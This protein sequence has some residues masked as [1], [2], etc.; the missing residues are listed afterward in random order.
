M[1]AAPDNWTSVLT[2]ALPCAADAGQVRQ[3]TKRTAASTPWPGE[4]DELVGAKKKPDWRAGCERR[5]MPQ[6]FRIDLG[7]GHDQQARPTRSYR[8]PTA[9]ETI[10]IVIP[11]GIIT[12]PGCLDGG[13]AI[14]GSQKNPHQ[15]RH[16][17]HGCGDAQQ[18]RHHKV[19]DRA[20]PH[21][22]VGRVRFCNRRCHATTAA[23]M[24]APSSSD[25][26]GATTTCDAFSPSDA[27][28]YTRLEKSVAAR[29]EARPLCGSVRPPQTFHWESL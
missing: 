6:P 19:A 10:V 23:M 3:A 22:Q 21:V 9:A 20:W 25:T 5:Q 2:T 1:P 26:R 8:R 18:R 4:D 13:Q 29:C 28:P 17:L 7:A 27:R 24:P 16:P 15:R 11:P 12:M 14:P